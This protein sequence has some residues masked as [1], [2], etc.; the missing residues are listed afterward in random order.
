MFFLVNTE[1]ENARSLMEKMARV[2][3]EG[4]M[5]KCSK[6]ELKSYHSGDFVMID[7]T[8]MASGMESGKSYIVYASNNVNLTDLIKVRDDLEQFDIH[9][10]IV[11]T[12][13]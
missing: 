6:D 9:V 8:Q 13:H 11:R 2:K 1:N 10:G 5:V 4:E 7:P 3:K 12:R